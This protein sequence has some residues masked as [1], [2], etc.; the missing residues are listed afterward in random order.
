MRSPDADVRRPG[1]NRPL[2][3]AFPWAA[4][5]GLASSLIGGGFS[6]LGA[7]NQ[8]K[9]A[10]Q[11]AQ[12]QMDFQREM[13]GSRYQMTMRDMKLAGLNPILAYKQGG[14]SPPGGSSYSP[15][16][17]GAA[18]V[19]GASGAAA[20]AVALIRQN[21][22]L[23]NMTAQ[24]RL[25]QS[26]ID[27]QAGARA[28]SKVESQ[29]YSGKNAR[30]IWL[31]KHGTGGPASKAA[32]FLL[33]QDDDNS[34]KSLKNRTR[35]MFTPRPGSLPGSFSTL[36]RVRPKKRRQAQSNDFSRWMKKTRKRVY[37]PRNKKSYPFQRRGLRSLKR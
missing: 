14:G 2:L 25:I 8:N 32:Q 33:G 13:F 11:A 7:S 12:V 26:Q 29:I 35:K 19:Q 5:A 6:A 23:K 22:E 28:A 1:P 27:A 16:N 24:E 31:L 21:Q 18:G 20:S 9:A 34:A 3:V 17:V 37:G 4:A 30:S 36:G 15:V 10:K